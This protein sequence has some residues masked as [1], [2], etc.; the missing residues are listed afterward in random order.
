MYNGHRGHKTISNAGR[1][2]CNDNKVMCLKVWSPRRRASMLF[3]LEISHNS[4]LFYQLQLCMAG[5]TTSHNFRYYKKSMFRIT[6]KKKLLWILTISCFFKGSPNKSFTFILF[7]QQNDENKIICY[8]RSFEREFF[9]HKPR[10]FSFICS[11]YSKNFSEKKMSWIS[12]GEGSRLT[13]IY[14]MKLFWFR[15]L[16]A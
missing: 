8:R 6:W 9:F 2:A 4:E 1:F 15:T 13:H 10:Y 3:L 14:V 11:N 16:L 5:P 7:L 12:R